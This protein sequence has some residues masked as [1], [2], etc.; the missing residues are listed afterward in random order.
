MKATD[1]LK[2]TQGFRCHAR[3]QVQWPVT[4]WHETLFGQ[5]TV[6]HISHTGCQ[7]AGTMSVTVGMALKLCITP[8]H[9]DDQLS[10]EE[11]EVLWVADYQFGLG[12]RSV[13]SLDRRKLR[14]FLENAELG[15]ASV[16][17]FNLVAEKT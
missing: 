1:D 12:F 3:F 11:A 5:G 17:S 10:I 9:K 14:S 2:T 8:P 6:L 16:A 4:Y 13:A 15:T 7:V